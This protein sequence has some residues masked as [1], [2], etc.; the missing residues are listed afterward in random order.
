VVADSSQWRGLVRTPPGREPA[1]GRGTHR[2]VARRHRRAPPALD[3][4]RHVGLEFHPA[5]GAEAAWRAQPRTSSAPARLDP[6]DPD[7]FDRWVRRRHAPDRAAEHRAYARGST[8][9]PAARRD[10]RRR[11]VRRVWAR[12]LTSAPSVERGRPDPRALL[13]RALRPSRVPLPSA[14]PPAGRHAP[15]ARRRLLRPVGVG[16]LGRGADP[17]R[18]RSCRLFPPDLRA[19]SEIYADYETSRRPGPVGRVDDPLHRAAGVG[20]AD[21]AGR[22]GAPAGIEYGS[23]EARPDR[24]RL[25]GGRDAEVAVALRSIAQAA[26]AR[27]RR[28]IAKGGEPGDV[29]RRLRGGRGGAD[30]ACAPWS[31]VVGTAVREVDPSRVEAAAAGPKVQVRRRSSSSPARRPPVSPTPCRSTN[32]RRT[33]WWPPVAYWRGT[34]DAVGLGRT[35]R[36]PYVPDVSTCAA[37]RRPATGARIVHRAHPLRRRRRQVVRRPPPTTEEVGRG[38]A[39]GPGLPRRPPRPNRPPGPPRAARSRRQHRR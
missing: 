10:R 21:A 35:E 28:Q 4:L 22:A 12:L 29:D 32:G 9:R 16:D 2:A 20:L 27:V 36:R 31:S 25:A 37:A 23:L 7:G 5:L 17:I 39:P 38:H 34:A 15:R 30:P 24:V 11:D 1:W 8:P 18:L 6:Q 19:R 13:D 33:S 14:F 26:R 3:L